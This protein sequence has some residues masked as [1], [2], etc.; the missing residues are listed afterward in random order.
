MKKNMGKRLFV[1]MALTSAVA[2][3]ALTAAPASAASVSI[4]VAANRMPQGAACVYVTDITTGAT[5]NAGGV[6]FTQ[7]RSVT[8]RM[9]IN[10]GDNLSFEW[11][12]RD[13]AG[14][15]LRIDFLRAPSPLPTVWNIN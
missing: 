14:S 3:V 11:H 2:A 9:G 12:G 8:V 6:R 7:G 1:P 10:S 15:A 4:N 5:A 13:C